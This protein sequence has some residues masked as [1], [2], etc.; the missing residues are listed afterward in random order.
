MEQLDLVDNT[1][2]KANHNTEGLARRLRSQGYEL[3][4]SAVLEGN[5]SAQ[6]TFDLVA[7]KSDGL[8]DQMVAVAV[9]EHDDNQEV[10]LGEV[11]TFD[12][13]CYDCGIHDKVLIALPRLDS[14]ATRF[15]QSQRIRVF[16]N[17]SLEAF[18]TSPPPIRQLNGNIP[19]HFGTR[20]E[21]VQSLQDSGYRVKEGAKVKGKSGAEYTIDILA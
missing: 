17:N 10:S 8:I 7:R 13:K 6:H 4:Q 1:Q 2:S 5:S 20:T 9:A 11:F 3:E 21:F 15:A 16:D 12:D 18:L 14:V 19:T